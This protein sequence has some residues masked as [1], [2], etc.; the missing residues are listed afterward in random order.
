MSGVNNVY[1]LALNAQSNKY[2]GMP[3]YTAR[4]LDPPKRGEF[5]FW[6]VLLQ[7]KMLSEIK[8]FIFIL[9]EQ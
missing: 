3:V 8:I 1:D 9:M 5:G 6:D 4:S 7:K 2:A